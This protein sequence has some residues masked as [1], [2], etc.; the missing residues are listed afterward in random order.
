MT[1]YITY[2]RDDKEKSVRNDVKEN[3]GMTQYI[4]FIWDDIFLVI[5]RI[6]L[7]FFVIPRNDSDEESYSNK[8]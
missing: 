3:V 5:P 7:L 1:Q 4:T 6:F 8:R 2:V